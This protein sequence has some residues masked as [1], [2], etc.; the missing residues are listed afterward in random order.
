[1]V[2]HIVPT[3]SEAEIRG[4]MSEASPGKSMISEKQNNAN[5]STGTE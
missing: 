1:M 3:T 5:E 4:L 2:V